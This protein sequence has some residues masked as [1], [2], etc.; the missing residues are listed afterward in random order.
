MPGAQAHRH[1]ALPFDGKDARLACKVADDGAIERMRE[2]DH[3]IAALH[4]IEL[5]FDHV[6]DGVAPEQ[7]EHHHRHGEGNADDGQ[8]AVRNGRPAILRSIMIRRGLSTLG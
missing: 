7:A 6:V 3:G 1:D 5:N 2:G 8:R 4:Q